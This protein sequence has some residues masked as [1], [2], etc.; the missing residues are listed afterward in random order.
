MCEKRVLLNP[1]TSEHFFTDFLT[2]LSHTYRPTNPVNF[3]LP[4]RFCF[5]DLITETSSFYITQ[6]AE[7]MQKYTSVYVSVFLD[8]L[9]IVFYA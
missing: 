5:K 1:P 9:K 2:H 4:K 7:K 3:D 8:C 6:T